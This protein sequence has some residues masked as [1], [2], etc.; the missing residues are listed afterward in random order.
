MGTAA[1]TKSRNTY[2]ALAEFR[3]RLREFLAFSEAAAH[4]AGLHPQQHQ[5]ILAIAGA[6]EGQETTVAYAAERLG[7]K[8]NSAVELANRCVG[9]GLLC[10]RAD[11]NDGRK[12]LL[13]VTPLGW[14][15]LKRLTRAHAKELN[16]LAPQLITSLRHAARNRKTIS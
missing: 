8:H 5:L 4:S 11:K 14:T 9:E 12:I 6:P 7:V 15:M 2:V 16:V 1:D 10:R 13:G 3:H